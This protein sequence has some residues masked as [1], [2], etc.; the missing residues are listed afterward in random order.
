VA[1]DLPV[2]GGRGKVYVL[3]DGGKAARPEP[4]VLHVA[5]GDCVVVDLANETDGP[6]SFHADLLAY[7]PGSSG[8]V[9]AGQSPDRSVAPGARGTFT[10][11]ADPEVG[12]GVA[13][14]RDFGDPLTNPAL[15]LY[16]AVVIGPKGA[17]QPASGWA[18][19]IDPPDDD[20]YRD[21]T[22]FLQDEDAGIG[23]HRMPYSKRVA[24][25][26]ALN[27]AAEPLEERLTVDPDP[28]SLFLRAVHGDPA[29]PV[30]EAEAGTPLRLHVLAPWSEQ[31]QVFSLEGHRWPA[32]PGRRGADRLSS[33]ILGGLEAITISPEGGA[34]GWARRP[35]DYLFG[36]HRGPYQE[37]GLW[38]VVRVLP[39][40]RERV[41]L[42]ARLWPALSLAAVLVGALVLL[43]RRRATRFQRRTW[44]GRRGA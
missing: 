40:R 16:G 24:G 5:V 18:V 21:V 17:A 15:G 22:L 23:S 44:S 8:G 19:S 32:E 42:V 39:E 41:S 4:L 7:A 2:F 3:R 30:V 28:G 12:E 6:V 27:Y 29:T 26:V 33:V 14:V 13:L 10:F 25:P 20:P 11:Y 1:A 35:G 34:G 38:G 37:A 36:D 9:A 43:V 31:A